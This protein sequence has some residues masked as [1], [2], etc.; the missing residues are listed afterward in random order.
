MEYIMNEI[1]KI[2][3]ISQLYDMMYQEK[4]LHPLIGIID[5]SKYNIG[6]YNQMKVSLGFYSI[7]YK[8][9]CPGIMR[10]GRNYYDFQEGTLTFTAPNQVIVIDDL[11]DTDD[12]SGWALIF[13]PD[14]IRGTSLST[15]MKEYNFFSYDLHEALHVSDL[16]LRRLNDIVKDIENELKQNIDKH[17][18]ALV[19]SSIELLLNYCN[20]YYDR[21]F[22]TRTVKNKDIITD[23]EKLLTDYF[24]SD[25]VQNSGFPSIKYFAEQLHLSP[26]YLSDLLKK[27]TGKNGTEH[28]QYHV[29]ELAKNRLLS[30]S[31]SVNEIAYDLGFGYPQYF[32]KMFKKNTGMT[33]VEY[34]KLN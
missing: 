5:F 33:P 8:N 18:K 31:V 17:S 25:E 23:F 9:F 29:I 7:M 19:V 21:Q 28:I 13:H 11:E 14:L 20:R 2:E 6:D 16:E 32:S 12:V 10:Y 24:E 34:R 26:N 3:N 4:P 1:V 15:K 30:S 22:I 27:E